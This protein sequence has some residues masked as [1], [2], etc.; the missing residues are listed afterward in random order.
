MQCSWCDDTA[1]TTPKRYIVEAANLTYN[2]SWT[3]TPWKEVEPGWIVTTAADAATVALEQAN[4]T[5][6]NCTV[7][8]APPDDLRG[9][10][11][12]EDE[13]HFWVLGT[14]YLVAYRLVEARS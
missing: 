11:H 10:I 14:G 3:L 13:A 6:D 2:G 12:G 5:I 1:T 4:A 7:S 8:D 9:R